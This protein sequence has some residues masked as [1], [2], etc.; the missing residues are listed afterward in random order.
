MNIMH[1]FPSENLIW[2]NIGVAYYR[3][4]MFH[5]VKIN[6]YPDYTRQKLPKIPEL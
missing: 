4:N 3:I 5:N 6:L 2:R 1:Y